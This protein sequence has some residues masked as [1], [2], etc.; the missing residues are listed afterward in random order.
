MYKTIQ[1]KT[2]GDRFNHKVMVSPIIEMGLF[3]TSHHLPPQ[4]SHGKYAMNKMDHLSDYGVKDWI[5]VTGSV[6]FEQMESSTGTP[7]T[8]WNRLNTDGLITKPRRSGWN[9]RGV[10][11][12]LLGR[13]PS[14]TKKST[15]RV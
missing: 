12:Y 6:S 2:F 4:I 8:N 3:F 1:N 13:T 7:R 14:G 10:K 5:L 11:G 15:F 9:T